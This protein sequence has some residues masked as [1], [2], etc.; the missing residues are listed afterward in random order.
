MKTITC[1]AYRTLMS[2]LCAVITVFQPSTGSAQQNKISP[3]LLNRQGER[4]TAF[5]CVRGDD[6]PALL[7][8]YGC[9]IIRQQG[10]IYVADMTRR[11]M[12][13]LAAEERVRRIEAR[14]LAHLAMDTT[15]TIV[16]ASAEQQA[17]AMITNSNG[18]PFTGKG[19]VMGVMDIG[20]DLTHP[21]FRHPT[22]DTCRVFALWD[23]LS[24]DTL[25]SRT[26]L[27]RDYKGRAEIDDVKHTRDAC[28]ASHGTHTAGI[29]TGNGFQGEYAGIAPECDICLVG[30]AVVENSSLIEE[31]LLERFN[32]VADALG[33]QYIFEQ[34]AERGLPCVASLSEGYL[35]TMSST[36]SLF[37]EYLK[38]LTGP[39]RI[40]VAAAGNRALYN[41]HIGKPSG[42]RTI[43]SHLLTTDANP[44]LMIQATGPFTLTVNDTLRLTPQHFTAPDYRYPNACA[45][46]DSIYIM[47]WNNY[48]NEKPPSSMPVCIEGEDADV[49]LY[50][51]SSG[52]RFPSME[53]DGMEE[54]ADNTRCILAPA[55]FPGIIA[56]GATAYRN[57]IRN[58]KGETVDYSYTGGTDGHLYTPSSLGPSLDGRLKPEVVAPGHCVVSSYGS[59]YIENRPDAYD[60]S[61][62][63]IKRFE[64]N[65]RTYSWNSNSGTSM[66]APVVAGVIA[67]WLQAKPSLTPEEAMQLIAETSTPP[68]DA[69]TYPNN[70]YGYGQINAVGGLLRLAGTGGIE[71]LSRLPATGMCITSTAPGTLT[72]KTAIPVTRPF[73]VNIYTL[74]GQKKHQC[75]LMP[76]SDGSNSITVSIPIISEKL[77]AIHIDS[78][79]QGIK[80][81]ALVA[82]P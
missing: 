14:G 78:S 73:T 11:E 2:L 36:D 82:I 53:Y 77:V 45:P 48:S 59:Y 51:L 50:C 12:M 20:F 43:N 55:C 32:T 38:K 81:T 3:W 41:R 24:T 7:R 46:G 1:H 28:I 27:G 72:I 63:D 21:T 26:P 10:D 30:N 37:A 13:A 62:C 40:I 29:A 61:T 8:R 15:S 71:H 54:F 76:Q 79:Q 66:S 42:N 44:L 31:H 80:G 6:A 47:A 74:N 65:G 19:V 4:V 68:V 39:G 18:S 16:H 5:V 64:Y 9:N 33:F 56:V 57:T 49:H 35:C 34:A 22:A 67:L 58:Y 69:L 25:N 23:M 52:T 17:A 70:S 75:T 60:V